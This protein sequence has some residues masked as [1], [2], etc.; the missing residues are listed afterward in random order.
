[1]ANTLLDLTYILANALLAFGKDMQVRARMDQ[2]A[3]RQNE[4]Q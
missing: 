3:L 2:V 4:Q 1:M